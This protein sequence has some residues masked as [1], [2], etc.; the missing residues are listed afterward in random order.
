MK[1]LLWFPSLLTALTFSSCGTYYHLPGHTEANSLSPPA[2]TMTQGESRRILTAG[3]NR[4]ILSLPPS[5]EIRSS[6]PEVAGI[7]GGD[8]TVRLIAKHP[9]EAT[10]YYHAF[11][12]SPENRGFEVTVLA[13]NH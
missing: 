12:R 10:V 8:W 6:N 5:I 4:P 13:A 1:S 11:N 3:L 7:T 2:I 9:G